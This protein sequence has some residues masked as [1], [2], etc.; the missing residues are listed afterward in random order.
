[1]VNDDT[2]AT[3]RGVEGVTFQKIINYFSIHGTVPGAYVDANSHLC[4]DVHKHFLTKA[5]NIRCEVKVPQDLSSFIGYDGL[6]T[7]TNNV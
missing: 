3:T 4:E 2:H 7:T 6:S 1:M 5:Q